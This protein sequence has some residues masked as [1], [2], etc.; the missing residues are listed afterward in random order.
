MPAG[1]KTGAK[2]KQNRQQK[3]AL[4]KA[5][6]LER[7][8]KTHGA[9][10]GAAVDARQ[11]A[12]RPVF[13]AD[14]LGMDKVGKTAPLD[15]KH[16]ATKLG[17]EA[18]MDVNRRIRDASRPLGAKS[19]DPMCH[20]TQSLSLGGLAALVGSACDQM[21]RRPVSAATMS[22]GRLHYVETKSFRRWRSDVTEALA[23]RGGY[24]PCFEQNLQVWRQLWRVLERCDVA[25]VV[26]DARHPLLHLPPA[27]LTHILGSLQKPMVVVLNKLDMVL[28]AVAQRWA[29]ELAAVIPGAQVVGFSK[30]PLDAGAFAPLPL[31]R[32]A[33]LRAAHAC[34]PAGADGVLLGMVGHP[35]VGKSSLVNALMQDKVVS[36]KATPGHTK[37]LQTLVL[38]ER[39]HLIDSPGLV[40]P[41]LDAHREE[42]VVGMLIPIAQVR[43]P[44][45]ALRWVMEHPAGEETR[46]GEG[47]A[48]ALK[49]RPVP[50]RDASALADAGVD[51]QSWG[52]PAP[53]D[54]DAAVPWSPLL[55][56]AQ[57][58]RARGFVRGAQ[59]DCLQAGREILEKV[60]EGKI[61]YAV[62]VAGSA[63]PATVE[64]AQGAVARA[65]AQDARDQAQD[66]ADY[67][68]GD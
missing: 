21:P 27:L 59:P 49:L 44:Y 60:L 68:S 63:S 41:R 61:A 14:D 9:R 1:I 42:Q 51:L 54:P 17:K 37:I 40:F 64:A 50:G 16:M 52:G 7:A 2:A 3:S 31:G 43:E 28:P 57:Y 32:C 4:A 48:R 56:C 62:P 35:N 18:A 65:A 33:L 13:T 30:E 55:L 10:G 19:L 25:V 11:A 20:G 39:T 26:V 36:V 58:A 47:L 12:A 34:A 45:S 66:E 38:D 5:C 29:R 67:V 22:A 53:D 23:A 8:A 46:P 15:A 24:A 6:A